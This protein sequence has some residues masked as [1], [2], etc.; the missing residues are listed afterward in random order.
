VNISHVAPTPIAC[1][2]VFVLAIPLA[3][4]QATY[5]ALA[6]TPFGKAI[7]QAR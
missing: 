2:L 6:S 1:F 7:S 3:Q 4:G 5:Q